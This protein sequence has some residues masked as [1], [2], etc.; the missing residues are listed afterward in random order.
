MN[1]NDLYSTI[2][3]G[4]RISLECKKAKNEIPKSVWETYSSFANTLGGDILLGVEEDFTAKTPSERFTITGVENPSKIKTDLWNTLNSEKVS[5]NLLV[6]SDVT[7]TEIDGKTVICIHV[8]QA[9]FTKRPVYINGNPIKGSFRRNHEGDYHCTEEEVRAMMRD[10]N[11]E[12]NDSLL[13]E[14]YNMDDIDPESLSQYRTEFRVLNSGHTW[15]NLDDKDFL[16]QLGGYVIDRRS[17]K[18]GLSLAGLLMFGK[19][20]SI[21]E[22]FANFR[23]DYVDMSHLVGDERYHDRLTYDGRWENNMYQF[24][25]LVNSKLTMDL[26]RPFKLKGIRRVDDTP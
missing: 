23:M 11:A 1:K 12:G 17:G 7:E 14:Y 6:D 24:F 2:Q 22:R 10:A 20:L 15:N 3:Q 16:K 5:F 9:N 26:P 21:R 25:H 13:V 4:E 8:P 19:G 18:E